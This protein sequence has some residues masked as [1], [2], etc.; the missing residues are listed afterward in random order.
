MYKQ[1]SKKFNRV[2]YKIIIIIL[3]ICFT[4]EAVFAAG[5]KMVTVPIANSQN[6]F[7]E[8]IDYSDGS[9]YSGVLKKN[10]D[11]EM[12]VVS[13]TF[14]PKDSKTIT[15]EPHYTGSTSPESTWTYNKDGYSGQLSLS[16][17][18]FLVTHFI[19]SI[20]RLVLIYEH[21]QKFIFKC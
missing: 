5:S 11:V 21:Q 10:G 6:D 9:G 15:D 7:I 4:S 3:L 12:R 2:V 1:K 18:S 16:S 17:G 20:L 13:G 19:S 14:T 8:R